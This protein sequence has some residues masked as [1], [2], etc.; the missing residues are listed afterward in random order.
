MKTKSIH[1]RITEEVKG[2]IDICAR[3]EKK[4]F[5]TFVTEWV[6]M[7]PD[8]DQWNFFGC[9]LFLSEKNN[10]SKMDAMRRAVEREAKQQGYKV[11]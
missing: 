8:L 5:S 4:K 7:L 1:F 10:I 9:L 2:R 6:S 11:E 3:Y